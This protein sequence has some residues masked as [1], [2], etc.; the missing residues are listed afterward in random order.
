MQLKRWALDGRHREFRALDTR[1]SDSH[2]FMPMQDPGDLCDD[3]L[4]DELR[5]ALQSPQWNL[6]GHASSDAVAVAGQAS[7]GGE[8]V[9]VS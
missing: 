2:K 8:L 3:N 7:D 4:N 6:G 5:Q 1:K 9:T